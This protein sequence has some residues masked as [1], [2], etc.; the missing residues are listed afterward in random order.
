MTTELKA[1]TTAM[2]AA[3]NAM[4]ELGK[5]H[6]AINERLR[7]SL[8]TTLAEVP[9]IVE[10]SFERH[11]PKAPVIKPWSI[12]AIKAEFDALEECE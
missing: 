10:R 5:K 3:L 8:D 1:Q 12:E 6:A 7:A 11:Y 4:A 9:A 2:E